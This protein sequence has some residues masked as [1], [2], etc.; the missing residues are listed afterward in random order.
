MGLI[1]NAV[2][3]LDGL[4]KNGL[5]QKAMKL[6]GLMRKKGKQK[7]DGIGFCIEMLE[8]GHSPIVA[9][10]IGLVE[11]RSEEAQC[12]IQRLREKGKGQGLK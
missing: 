1:P 2:A 6:F 7:E 8:V 9:T 3:V 11:K 10:Y 12:V 4:C 5:I